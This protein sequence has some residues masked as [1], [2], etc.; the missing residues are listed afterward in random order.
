[1]RD[2]K[3]QVWGTSLDGDGFVQDLGIYEDFEDISLHTN[4]FHDMVISLEQVFE[5]KKE[6]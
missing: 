4:M 5:D 3:I 1:M 6:S 2:W